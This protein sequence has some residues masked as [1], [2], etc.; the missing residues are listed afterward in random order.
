MCLTNR[1]VWFAGKP[2]PTGCSS[3]LTLD[4]PDELCGGFQQSLTVRCAAT[5]ATQVG[6]RAE[7][8]DRVG[9]LLRLHHLDVHSVLHQLQLHA[10]LQMGRPAAIH[11]PDG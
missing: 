4:Y 2:A 10:E 8:A 9:W 7:H 3:F 5:L 1:V 6:T 11:A